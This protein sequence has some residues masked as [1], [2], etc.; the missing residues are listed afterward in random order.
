MTYEQILTEVKEEEM[1]M[2]GELAKRY[3]ESSPKKMSR[4]SIAIKKEDNGSLNLKQLT[5][6]TSW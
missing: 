3:G 2:N 5:N 6:S 4:R 1:L